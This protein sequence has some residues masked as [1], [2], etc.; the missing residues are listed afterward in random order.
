MTS[1]VV[2]SSGRAVRT[3]EGETDFYVMQGGRSVSGPFAKDDK[4]FALP[5][6]RRELA[7]R[8]AGQA[9]TLNGK[10]ARVIGRLNDFA[11]IA[12][13]DVSVDAEFAWETVA[14]V[15]EEKGGAF[16]S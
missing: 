6:T 10:P 1:R 13:L 2:A 15:M 16:R 5:P 11:T 14:R 7:N 12:A 3:V 4:R 8:Y 9:C